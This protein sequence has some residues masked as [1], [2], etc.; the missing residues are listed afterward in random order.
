MFF[1][2]VA[3]AHL[4]AVLSRG[5]PPRYRAPDCSERDT[6]FSHPFHMSARGHV[7]YSEGHRIKMNG[8]TVSTEHPSLLSCFRLTLWV[9]RS[10]DREA[11]ADYFDNESSFIK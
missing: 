10:A 8:S 6:L 11:T 4:A 7:H 5:E 3:Q 9:K 1:Q 2:S